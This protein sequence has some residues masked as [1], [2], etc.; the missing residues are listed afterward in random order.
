METAGGAKIMLPLSVPMLS[1]PLGWAVL[2]ATDEMGCTSVLRHQAYVRHIIC[3][4][5][6]SP[7][8]ANIFVAGPRSPL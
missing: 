4:I 2:F 5:L 3:M 7:L 1:I 6:F 8:V